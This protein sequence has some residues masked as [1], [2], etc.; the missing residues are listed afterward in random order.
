M[1]P[2]G[3]KLDK[4]G[5]GALARQ[6]VAQYAALLGLLFLLALSERWDP[7]RRSF[8]A[9]ASSCCGQMPAMR[10]HA[11]S[12]AAHPQAPTPAS[13]RHACAAAGHTSD[14]D[15]WRYSYPLRANHVPAWA[16]PCIA[17]FT[18]T[19]LVVAWLLAGRIGRT[20]AHHAILLAVY[21]VATTGARRPGGDAAAGAS[22][23]AVQLG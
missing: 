22:R 6:H 13:M 11:C 16:V 7:F 23:Y 14:L 10:W 21:C 17:V 20:E 5:W 2:V 18:P 3:G 8:Y 15:I 9:G 1:M 12:A 19:L 4:A